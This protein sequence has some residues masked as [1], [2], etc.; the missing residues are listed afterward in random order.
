LGAVE[1]LEGFSVKS[2]MILAA[3]CAALCVS[4]PAAQ[5]KGMTDKEIYCTFMPMAKMCAPAAAKPAMAKPAMAKPAMAMAKP[6]A[7]KPAPKGIKMMACV[8][9][10]PG[11]GHLYS[12]KWK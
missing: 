5:A 7:A 6:A 3:L 4:V 12:C 2:V 10:E 8:K 9:A 11:K 1:N